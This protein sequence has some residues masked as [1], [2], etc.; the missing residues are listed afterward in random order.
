MK[1]L[2]LF[3]LGAL[4]GGGYW[5][6]RYLRPEHS[7]LALN[8]AVVVITGA[9]G[10]IGRAYAVAF[11]KR[12]AKVVLAAR[13][14]EAL[15]KVRAEI[16]PY[17]ADVLVVPTDM[18]NDDQLRGLVEAVLAKYGQID[19]LVNN[20]GLLISGPLQNNTPS[21]IRA[22]IDTNV[23]SVMAL[24]ALFLP[25]MLARRSGWVVNVASTAG[26]FAFTP[27]A[28]YAPAKK[29]LIAFSDTLRRQVFDTGVQVVNVM[30]GYTDTDMVEPHVQQW[31][32]KSGFIIDTPDY[33]AEHSIDGLLKGEREI[34]FGGS[35]MRFTA[36][37]EQHWPRLADFVMARAVPPSAMAVYDDKLPK[38]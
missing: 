18:R 20:A 2:R 26:K 34:W 8:G 37:M 12:G 3:G 19:V 23:A 21:E 31:A 22:L 10:G 1:L 13:R 17:A 4:V 11:A 9:S 30:P 32:K 35:F 7:T 33:V 29:G 24:T 38:A 25:H 36:W 15:E 6:Y 27:Y 14:A 16:A 28:V 5:L